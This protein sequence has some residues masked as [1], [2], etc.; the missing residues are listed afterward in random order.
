MGI[1][2][3]PAMKARSGNP[4]L[5]HS[6]RDDSNVIPFRK[7][8]A[9]PAQT[10]HGVP[11]GTSMEVQAWVDDDPD[12]ALAALKAE[13]ESTKPRVTL[14]G[15]LH[16]VLRKAGIDPAAHDR[17]AEIAAAPAPLELVQGA[18]DTAEPSAP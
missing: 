14:L 2:D 12:R 1:N 15:Y 18:V 6:L 9:P 3:H 11:V 10:K 13:E 7:R 5:P 16:N 8:T 17:P 4:Y